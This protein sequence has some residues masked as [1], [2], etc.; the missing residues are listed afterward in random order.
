MTALEQVQ[1]ISFQEKFRLMEAIWD[2]IAREGGNS[3]V[4][5]WHEE[6][7]NECERLLAEGDATFIDWEDAKARIKAAVE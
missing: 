6:I 3:E 7:L 2:Q 5:Q 1:E 4:P